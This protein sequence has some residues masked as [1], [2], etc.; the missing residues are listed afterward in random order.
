MSTHKCPTCGQ[1]MPEVTGWKVD[2]REID[3][4]H[5]VEGA[6]AWFFDGDEGAAIGESGLGPMA[7]ARELA[8]EARKY[9]AD[10]SDENKSE[11]DAAAVEAAAFDLAPTLAVEEVPLG[12]AIPWKRGAKAA[13]VQRANILAAE[14]LKVAQEAAGVKP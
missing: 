8:N 5:H 11:L 14:A 6:L 9:I 2:S 4:S 13:I 3:H 12:R 7:A 10:R 1:T